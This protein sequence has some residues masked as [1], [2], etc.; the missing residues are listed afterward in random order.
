MYK[1]VGP[2]IIL[3]ALLFGLEFIT[4]LSMKEKLLYQQT[5]TEPMIVTDYSVCKHTI[6]NLKGERT[7]HKLYTSNY[8]YKRFNFNVNDVITRT[9]N[10]NCVERTTIWGKDTIYN[11]QIN[12]TD[13]EYK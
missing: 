11:F 6:V 1:I 9:Y 13:L 10:W 7:G 5:I 8:Y 12:L 2:I 3:F 4:L